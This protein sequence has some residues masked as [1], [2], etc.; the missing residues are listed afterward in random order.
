MTYNIA[1][2]TVF[3]SS[4][5][6][7]R[8]AY[9]EWLVTKHRLLSAQGQVLFI[10]GA[11]CFSPKRP[12]DHIQENLLP[13]RSRLFVRV[14]FHLSVNGSSRPGEDWDDKRSDDRDTRLFSHVDGRGKTRPDEREL[15]EIGWGVFERYGYS[16]A[17]RSGREGQAGARAR[18]HSSE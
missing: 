9:N 12:A 6:R 17:R 3:P 13:C 16:R 2:R 10:V 15:R 11:I 4:V 8:C 14:G 7:P 1:Y 18:D 5:R